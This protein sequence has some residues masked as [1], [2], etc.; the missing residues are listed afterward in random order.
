MSLPPSS[1]CDRLH[2]HPKQ[3]PTGSCS[4]WH[5][6]LGDL[7]W[8]SV[9]ETLDT[10]KV[11]GTNIFFAS[12]RLLAL[13]ERPSLNIACYRWGKNQTSYC[14]PPVACGYLPPAT[15]SVRSCT[16]GRNPSLSHCFCCIR[17]V[18]LEHGDL[19]AGCNF[20]EL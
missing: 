18:F 1:F 5:Q 2:F 13:H 10:T 12:R 6:L 11:P 7:L 16:H 20:V 8:P 9:S 15:A 4:G 14:V 17:W 3:K 19:N